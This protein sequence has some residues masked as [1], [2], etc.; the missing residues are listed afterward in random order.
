MIIAEQQGFEGLK[1]YLMNVERHELR[2]LHAVLGDEV[3]QITEERFDKSVDPLGKKWKRL[4][5]DYR[6]NGK[7]VRAKNDRPL[8]YRKL[9]KSFSY[10]ASADGVRIGTPLKYAKYHTDFPTN[11]G[12]RRNRIPL[13]EFMGIESRPDEKRIMDTAVEWMETRMG[14]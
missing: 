5:H 3:V 4:K 1:R 11:N 2:S 10:D 14:R 12:A 8:K 7:L 9:Y 6:K 13:R